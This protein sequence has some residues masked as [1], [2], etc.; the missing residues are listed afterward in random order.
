MSD[1]TDLSLTGRVRLVININTCNP[2]NRQPFTVDDLVFENPLPNSSYDPR[3]TKITIRP[4]DT[5]RFSGKRTLFY[6]RIDLT[7]AI[8]ETWPEL[9]RPGL[10]ESHELLPVLLEECGINL[11]TEDVLNESLVG[12]GDYTFTA[13]PGSIGWVG[14]ATVLLMHLALPPDDSLILRVDDQTLLDLGGYFMRLD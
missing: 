8:G 12:L 1:G 14:E 5:Q 13:S 3:N 11:E 4:T 10:T 6:R 9:V 7:D 2:Q